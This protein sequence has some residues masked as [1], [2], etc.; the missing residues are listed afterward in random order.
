MAGVSES[1]R[2]DFKAMLP[3]N[4]QQEKQDQNKTLS[5]ICSAFA[6][7]RGGFVILGVSQKSGSF[8]LDGVE[9]N[10]EAYG[11]FYKKLRVEPDIRVE[12]PL[13]IN[14]ENGKV[15]YVF[16]IPNSLAKPHLPTRE[17]ERIFWKRVGSDCKQ[18][19]LQ[20][21]RSLMNNYQ[22]MREQLTLI[23]MDLQTKISDVQAYRTD[24]MMKTTEFDAY[25]FKQIDHSLAAAFP[26]V[27]NEREL[28][29]NLWQIRTQFQIINKRRSFMR[30][31]CTI[32][33]LPNAGKHQHSNN[34]EMELSTIV[35]NITQRFES[36]SKRMKDA[37]DVVNPYAKSN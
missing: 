1:D 6:N 18:M 21:V 19:S 12:M 15:I 31:I 9:P 32:I 3:R 30:H 11:D 7:T 24:Y 17:E 37:Y 34:I 4:A 2:H 13:L 14:L 22:A 28:I 29:E 23:V 36:I 8:L 25:D 5:K 27:Q 35:L 20:E 26:L 16:E 10:P 33:D